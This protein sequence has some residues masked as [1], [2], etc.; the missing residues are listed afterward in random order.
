M[1]IDP[2]EKDSGQVCSEWISLRDLKQIKIFPICIGKNIEFL[3]SSINP[4][5]LG[6]HFIN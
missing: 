6:S 4:V 2:T 1:K 5:Y 3:I